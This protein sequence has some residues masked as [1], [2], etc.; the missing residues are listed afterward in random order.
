MTPEEM[1]NLITSFEGIA[2]N[3]FNSDQRKTIVREL[4]RVMMAIRAMDLSE[5]ARE[6]ER[7]QKRTA[8]E[9]K[10][11]EYHEYCASLPDGS[12]KPS[13]RSFLRGNLNAY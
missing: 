2:H 13:I 7:L 9:R 6:R 12:P 11:R 10:K 4:N 1:K 3:E 8:Y 5:Q